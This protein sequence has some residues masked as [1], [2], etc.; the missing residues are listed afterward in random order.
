MWWIIIG[1]I[2]SYLIGAIPTAYIFGK[3]LK[4]IDIRTVGSGNVGATNAMRLLGKGP[5]IAVLLLDV[6]KG[7]LVTAFIA[8]F[9]SSRV[10]FSDSGEF[11]RLVTGICC[12]C[13]HNWTLFLNFKGGKGVA[14]TLGVLLGVAFSSP[15]LFAVLG[16]VVLSWLLVFILSKIISLASLLAA[17]SF[18]VY[19]FLFKQSMVML[20]VGSL[21]ALLIIVRHKANLARLFKGAEPRI[22]FRKLQQ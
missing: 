21:L 15:Q 16:L 13:G 11:Y 14:T 9:V 19:L 6:L 10:S 20:T 12:I 7:I 2:V 5:G 22:S 17:V 3:V 8:T 18:P 4:G 1:I